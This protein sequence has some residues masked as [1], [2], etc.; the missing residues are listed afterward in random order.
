MLALMVFLP[1]ARPSRAKRPDAVFYTIIPP[2]SPHPNLAVR[3]HKAEALRAVPTIIRE[4]Y[5]DFEGVSYSVLTR[6]GSPTNP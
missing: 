3:S 2:G 6:S 5:W 1:F 4:W